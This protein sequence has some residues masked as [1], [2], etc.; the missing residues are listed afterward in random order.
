MKDKNFNQEDI[1]QAIDEMSGEN[2]FSKKLAKELFGD[3]NIEWTVENLQEAILRVEI[4]LEDYYKIIDKV[5][6]PE[7][8]FIRWGNDL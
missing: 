4:R 5:F 7:I 1:K 2:G 3:E 6:D 8:E